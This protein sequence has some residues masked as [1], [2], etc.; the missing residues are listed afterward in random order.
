MSSVDATSLSSFRIQN[1]DHWQLSYVTSRFST[2]KL[3]KLAKLWNK[4]LDFTLD[5]EL[6]KAMPQ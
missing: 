4:R 1:F 6:K 3:F 5:L 2:S